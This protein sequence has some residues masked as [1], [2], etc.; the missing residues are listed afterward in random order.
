MYGAMIILSD[1]CCC[2]NE[3]DTRQIGFGCK[4][5]T[6]I[7]IFFFLCYPLPWLVFSLIV[8][9]IF[10]FFAPSLR[11]SPFHCLLLLF[12]S[13]RSYHRDQQ[14]IQVSFLIFL[15]FFLLFFDFPILRSFLGG[16]YFFVCGFLLIFRDFF[17]DL[18]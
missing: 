6:I 18:V 5:S 3:R 11:A 8:S 1:I 10:I 9:L 12:L 2:H 7:S 14:P 13:T 17:S 15:H 4:R 16:C